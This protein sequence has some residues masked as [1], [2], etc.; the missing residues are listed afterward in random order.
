[1]HGTTMIFL[2][3]M[4]LS[5]AFANYLVPLMI[6]ARDV[7]FPRLNAFGYW[8]FLVGGLF[9][10]SSFIFG[11]APNGGWF[12]YAPQTARPFS[13]GHNI[14]FWILGLQILGIASLTGAINLIITIINMRAPG[15]S[16]MRMPI[17]AWMTLVAQFLL[18]FAIPVITVAL[19]LLMFD[20]LFGSNFFNVQAGA[21]PLLWQHLFWIFGHP[22]VY[23]L[24]LPAMG[25][26]SEVL[27]VFTRRPLF[28][29]PVMVFSGI[30]IAFLG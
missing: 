26:V 10:Y 15:M 9:M 24:I 3:I 16:M 23:I 21:D 25:I 2:V 18:L 19:F 30:A 27:P 11:G 22:E 28:G 20:R 14:D 13:A 12:G 7:A 6:G 8:T 17:F 29:Y 4:P 5:A 1:M